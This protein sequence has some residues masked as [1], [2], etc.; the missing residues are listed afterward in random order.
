MMH[1]NHGAFVKKLSALSHSGFKLSVC[2]FELVHNL[3]AKLIK[4]ADNATLMCKKMIFHAFLVFIL[5]HLFLD[6]L[7]LGA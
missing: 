4:K 6:I 2:L 1:D 7:D 3:G 5:F